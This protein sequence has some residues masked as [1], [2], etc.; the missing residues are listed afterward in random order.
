MVTWL[1]IQ[2]AY[3]KGKNHWNLRIK[4]VGFWKDLIDPLNHRDVAT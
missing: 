4:K 1:Y 2:T 3:L